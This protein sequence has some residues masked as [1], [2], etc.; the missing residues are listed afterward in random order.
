MAKAAPPE[1]ELLAKSEIEYLVAEYVHL[2][3]QEKSIAA[4]KKALRDE[5]MKVVENTGEYD[6]SGNQ[7]V[8]LPPGSEVEMVQRQRRTSRSTDMDA[9]QEVLSAKGMES[10]AFILVPTLDED[11]VWRQV[12]EGKLSDSDLDLIFPTKETYALVVQ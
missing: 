11:F 9:A 7:F 8:E 3:D 5:L 1:R 12:F 6:S 2:R 10:E 4:R